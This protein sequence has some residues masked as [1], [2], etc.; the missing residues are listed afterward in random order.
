MSCFIAASINSVITDKLFDESPQKGHGVHGIEVTLSS[1]TLNTD[2]KTTCHFHSFCNTFLFTYFVLFSHF[3]HQNLYTFWISFAGK[4]FLLVL[5][6]SHD[7]WAKSAYFYLFK[8]LLRSFS[9]HLSLSEKIPL[10]LSLQ[11]HPL[12]NGSIWIRYGSLDHR[13][14]PHSQLAWMKIYTEV[15]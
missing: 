9:L 5:T 4:Y 3:L 2:G 6:T 1:S 8:S 11:L 15:S 7:C 12:H 13:N 10:W 14:C